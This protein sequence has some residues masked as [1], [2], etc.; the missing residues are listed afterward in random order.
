MPLP[1]DNYVYEAS[2]FKDAL[3][4]V[5]RIPCMAR[6]KTFDQKQ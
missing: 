4:L 1:C 5:R 2:M 3:H 6:E